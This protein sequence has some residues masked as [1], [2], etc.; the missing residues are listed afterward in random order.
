LKI[1]SN[2]LWKEIKW[3]DSYKK[4]SKIDYF[5]L[6]IFTLFLEKEISLGNKEWL[7]EDEADTDKLWSK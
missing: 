7:E 6:V 5:K 3:I 4:K 1:K 2:Y